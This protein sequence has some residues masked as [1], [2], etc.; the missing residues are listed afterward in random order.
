MDELPVLL[1]QGACLA[2]RLD[3]A[4]VTKQLLARLRRFRLL[5]DHVDCFQHV[6]QDA[7]VV[8][9]GM[10][11]HVEGGAEQLVEGYRL[12]HEAEL[13]LPV[14]AVGSALHPAG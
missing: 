12:E 13:A 1:D 11:Q 10:A 5:T 7:G 14:K 6:Q 9:T 4:D 8:A 3:E 2:F